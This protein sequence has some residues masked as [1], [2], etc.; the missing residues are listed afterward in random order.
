MSAP[1][2]EKAIALDSKC[3][4]S[5]AT[6]EDGEEDLHQPARPTTSHLQDA[7]MAF[8]PLLSSPIQNN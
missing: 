3:H 7:A 5:R 4:H 8:L 2:G 6:G 1:L